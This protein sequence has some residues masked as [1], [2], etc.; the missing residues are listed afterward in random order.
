MDPAI[1]AFLKNE[2]Q[3]YKDEIVHLRGQLNARTSDLN[4]LEGACTVMQATLTSNATAIANRKTAVRYMKPFSNSDPQ[5]RDKKKGENWLTFRRQFKIHCKSQGYNAE[6]SKGCLAMSVEGAAAESVA[7]LK[8]E[9]YGTIDEMLDAYEEKFLPPAA[10]TLA[11]TYFEQATQ[12][13]SETA[14][15][16]HSRL[17]T[18]WRRA[19]PNSTDVTPLIRRFAFGLLVLST[20]QEILRRQADTY[21]KALEIAQTEEAIQKATSR[22]AVNQAIMPARTMDEPMDI[23]AMNTVRCYNC[24][25]VGHI[26][27][28]CTKPPGIASA[29]PV[30]K[31]QASNGGPK[32]RQGGKGGAPRDRQ[33]R[34]RWKVRKVLN[35]IGVD[36]IGDEEIDQILGDDSEED[37]GEEE[38]PLS[39]QEEPEQGSEDF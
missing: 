18:L 37:E 14:L 7:E 1:I 34:R 9:D 28:D 17:F 27:R 12:T 3:P 23:N 31:P 5:G 22:T 2:L 13:A 10:S 36:N 4:R 25:T 8:P 39:L 20:R 38:S 6:Q 15:E 21:S 32:G 11:Q 30:R 16:W 24:N 35:A 33:A 19:Y 29:R 26:R